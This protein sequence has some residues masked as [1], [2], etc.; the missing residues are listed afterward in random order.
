[1]N[2]D[3]LEISKNYNS[4]L[5]NILSD[6]E[7]FVVVNN[8]HEFVVG[9]SG[10]VDSCLTVAL[11]DAYRRKRRN[12]KIIGRGLWMPGNKSSEYYTAEMVGKAFCDDFKMKKLSPAYYL[13]R[14]SMFPD[15]FL[16]KKDLALKI[17][18]GN[19]KARLRM[20][21]LYNE[22]AKRKGIVM[23]TDNLTELML[24]FWTLHGDVGD[25]GLIQSLW[26]TEVYGLAKYMATNYKRYD[27]EMMEALLASIRAVPTDGLGVSNSDFEQLGVRTYEEVDRRLIAYLKDGKQEVDCPVV[28]RHRTTNFKRENPVNI[29]REHLIN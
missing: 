17:R 11:L 28:Q 22:A 19:I 13:A 20:I 7:D 2:K 5:Q 12:V 1:M 23:S 15:T 26:K 8:I 25:F 21:Y 6:I 9:I 3:L 27:W 14:L 16:K 24:G 29:P 10:G 18:L 4:I